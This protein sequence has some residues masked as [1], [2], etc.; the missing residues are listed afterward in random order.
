[1]LRGGEVAAGGERGSEVGGIELVDCGVG[2][3]AV[4]WAEPLGSESCGDLGCDGCAFG[5]G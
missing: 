1:L 3:A 2:I 4:R 5:F